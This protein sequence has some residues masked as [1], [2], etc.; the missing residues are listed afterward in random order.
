M[1]TAD[2]QASIDKLLKDM[3]SVRSLPKLYNEGVGGRAAF[4]KA[5]RRVDGCCNMAK[6]LG[7]REE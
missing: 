2:T 5:V 3:F 6:S 4:R 7:V 1:A